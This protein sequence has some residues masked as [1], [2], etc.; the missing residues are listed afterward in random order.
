MIRIELTTVVK[1]SL[2]EVFDYLVDF[3][4]LPQYEPWVERVERTS[5]GPIRVGSTWTHVR[6][7]GRRRITAPIDL[8]EYEPPHRLAIVSGSGGVSVRATQRFDPIEGGTQV[9][10]L[11]EMTIRGPLRLLEPVIRRS[12]LQQGHE[13][14]RRF[15][16]ILESR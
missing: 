15:K 4:N 6:R 10:E 11:L 12:A 3:S 14:H 5:A 9:T 1:R 13:V 2:N 8:V 16:E 7:M